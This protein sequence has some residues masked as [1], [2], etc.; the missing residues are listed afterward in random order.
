MTIHVLCII[1]III[2]IGLHFDYAILCYVM[3]Y[4]IFLEAFARE[5]VGGG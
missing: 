2:F 1:T 5:L 4:Y 3:L